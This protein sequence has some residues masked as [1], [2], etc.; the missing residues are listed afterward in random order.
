[1]TELAEAVYALLIDGT[2][3]EIWPLR[4]QDTEAVRQKRQQ[5]SAD[6]PHPT[7]DPYLR[8]LR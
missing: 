5:M 6:T 2:E 4:L 1:M 8:K 3:I 7:W